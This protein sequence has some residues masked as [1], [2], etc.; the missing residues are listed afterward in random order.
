[1]PS[2]QLSPA[3]TGPATPRPGPP[4]AIL[5]Y[6]AQGRPA[7]PPKASQQ[8]GL[9]LPELMGEARAEGGDDQGAGGE[10]AGPDDADRDLID[11]IETDELAARLAREL[12]AKP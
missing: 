1:M 7:P 6:V 3:R 8:F 11:A 9:W 10:G 4:D 12:E 5:T 2:S